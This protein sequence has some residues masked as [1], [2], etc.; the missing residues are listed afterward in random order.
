MLLLAGCNADGLEFNGA[1][2]V[3]QFPVRKT[4]VVHYQLPSEVPAAGGAGYV[5]DEQTMINLTGAT[6]VEQGPAG[7]DLWA[8]TMSSGVCTDN[9]S[10]LCSIIDWVWAHTD[11]QQGGAIAHGAAWKGPAVIEAY[12]LSFQNQWFLR[13]LDGQPLVPA[14][15]G[16][17]PVKYEGYDFASMAISI[18][19]SAQ[20]VSPFSTASSPSQQEIGDPATVDA[21]NIP[22]IATPVNNVVQFQWNGATANPPPGLQAVGW[23]E[24]P[25]ENTHIETNRGIMTRVPVPDYFGGGSGIDTGGG[26]YMQRFVAMWEQITGGTSSLISRDDN[27]LYSYYLAVI[28][29]HVIGYGIGLVDSS[30]ASPGAINDQEDIMNQSVALDLSALVAAG[31]QFQFVTEDL[32]RMQD[33]VNGTFSAPGPKSTLPGPGRP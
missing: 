13:G 6:F 9:P 18:H 29:N 21:N 33:V 15:A 17:A 1:Q 4:P 23:H 32:L 14:V 7:H 12:V 5:V 26:V 10:P 16:Q 11:S 25:A 31:K 2:Q 30:F 28:G 22:R 20:A 3:E 24:L 27:V 8:M 19:E